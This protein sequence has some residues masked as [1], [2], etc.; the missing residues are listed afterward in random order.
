MLFYGY[1]AQDA[2]RLRKQL[3]LVMLF[4]LFALEIAS[5]PWCA[6][7]PTDRSEYA[8]V[9]TENMVVATA[10]P[11]LRISD[12]DGPRID[13]EAAAVVVEE[14][15]SAMLPSPHPLP[16][17]LWIGLFFAYVALLAFNL[18]AGYRQSAGLGIQWRWELIQTALF[19]IGWT[20]WDGYLTAPWFPFVLLKAGLMLY[21]AYL[22][23]PD[24][25]RSED[26]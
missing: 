25:A 7:A 24:R 15:G 9:P 4:F 6:P 3:T 22:V 14:P 13:D 10:V 8:A 1:F 12:I 19:L 16:A 17:G 11:V 26:A 18:I 2:G 21:A 5:L 20:V 23:W